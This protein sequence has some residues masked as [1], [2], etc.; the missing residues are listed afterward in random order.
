MIK[1][2]LL[3]KV[4]RI[5]ESEAP[6]YKAMGYTLKD[7]ETGKTIWEPEGKEDL[8][9]EVTALRTQLDEL[10][11]QLYAAN[12]KTERIGLDLVEAKN[13]ITVLSQANQVLQDENTEL[14]AKA[15]AKKGR[16]AKSS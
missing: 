4:V 8:Q 3:G 7:L 5:D 1:A 10:Q 16:V 13:K 14:K 2:R 6:K 15:E 11:R 9:K 12:N